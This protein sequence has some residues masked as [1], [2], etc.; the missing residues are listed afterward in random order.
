MRYK[1][2]YRDAIQNDASLRFDAKFE[3]F[4][5]RTEKHEPVADTYCRKMSDIRDVRNLALS[6][7][8][9]VLV[10]D[11]KVVSGRATLSEAEKAAASALIGVTL[12]P[13]WS[14]GPP[15]YF[16]DG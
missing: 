14:S 5:S 2:V 8:R 12:K 7:Q 4:A 13:L 15:A 10:K 9:F 11:G 3:I 6:Q 16:A 1:S